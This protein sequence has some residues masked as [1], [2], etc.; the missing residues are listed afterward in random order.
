[1]GYVL[2]PR[3][4]GAQT[5][6]QQVHASGINAGST[7]G[8]GSNRD[9]DSKSTGTSGRRSASNGNGYVND[10]SNSEKGNET[11]KGNISGS[12]GEKV[13]EQVKAKEEGGV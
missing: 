10:K 8:R 6:L 3:H 4:R 5:L 9:G 1:M 13:D 12:E 7:S 2:T 11:G